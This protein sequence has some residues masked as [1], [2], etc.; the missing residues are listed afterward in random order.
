MKQAL[1]SV[2]PRWIKTRDDKADRDK[3]I[4]LRKT[5]RQKNDRK[6]VEFDFLTTLKYGTFS[7]F[8]QFSSLMS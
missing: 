4:D 5:D 2:D 7:K 1:A 6:L 8:F 3:K